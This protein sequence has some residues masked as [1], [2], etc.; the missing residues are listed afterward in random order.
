MRGRTTARLLGLL[1]LSLSAGRAGADELPGAG[2]SNHL[3]ISLG[4]GYGALPSMTSDKAYVASENQSLAAQ[5]WTT[6]GAADPSSELHG[7]LALTYYGPYWTTLRVGVEAAFFQPTEQG[8]PPGGSLN[9]ITNYGGI[10]E[11]PILFG[12]HYAL[13]SDRL[14]LEAL[15]GPDVTLVTMSGLDS[16]DLSGNPRL[17]GNTS[18]GFDSEFG[19]RYLVSPLFSV[20]AELGYRALQ[21]GPLHASDQVSPYITPAGQNVGLDF[22]GFR[23]VIDIALVVL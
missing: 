1:L 11:L 21:T 4:F 5:G 8:T 18:V 3:A 17:V 6:S 2:F 15:V 12:A 10:V 20:G 23:G 14:I 22:S 16:T 7:E 9:V 13:A 19:V